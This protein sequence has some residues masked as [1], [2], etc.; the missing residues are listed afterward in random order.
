MGSEFINGL[1]SHKFPNSSRLGDERHSEVWRSV[2]ALKFHAFLFWYCGRLHIEIPLEIGTLWAF[3]IGLF[4][5]SILGALF[6]EKHLQH[7]RTALYDAW[8]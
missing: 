6:E 1:V 4:K 7:I 3:E 8:D 2:E 5:Y